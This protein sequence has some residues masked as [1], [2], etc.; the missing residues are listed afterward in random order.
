MTYSSFLR[1]VEALEQRATANT[2]LAEMAAAREFFVDPL[3]Q[4]AKAHK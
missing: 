3:G 2:L 1:R 4:K